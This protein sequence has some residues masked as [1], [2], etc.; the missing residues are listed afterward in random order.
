MKFFK[1]K[2]FFIA[3][4]Y[5]LSCQNLLAQHSPAKE[6]LIQQE[7]QRLQQMANPPSNLFFNG[8]NYDVNFYRLEIR[9]NPDSVKY[10]KG[11]VT[12][13]FKTTQSNVTNIVFDLASPVSYTAVKYHGSNLAASKINQ[14]GDDLTITLPNI[15][16]LGTLD[17]V[18]VFYE[19]VP[20]VV[21]YF[22]NGTGFVKSTHSGA[23]YIYTL[24]EPY[25]AYTWWPC[26]SM[27]A[28]DKADSMDIIISH[29]SGYKAAA[30]G[31]LVSVTGSGNYVTTFWKSRYPI[32]TYQVAI[33][34]AN[35]VQY[36]TTPDMVNIGGTMM[37][38]YNY[39]FPETNTSTARAVLDRTKLMLTTFSTYFGDYP[40]KNEKYG[41]YTFGFGG[42][43]EHNTFSGMNYGTY[44]SFSDWSVIAHELG[45]QWFG[46]NV[47]CGSWKDIWVNESFAQYSE[48][49][50]AELAPSV[51][52]GATGYSVR[53]NA[54]NLTMSSANQAKPIYADDT[55][56]INTI[57]TPAVY[58][59]ERGAMFISMLRKLLGDDNFFQ[60]IKNYQSDP[61]L[62]GGNAY[63]ND[64]KRHMEA[65]SGY[66]LTEMFNDW[67]YNTGVARYNGAK[68]NTSGYNTILYLPQTTQYSGI[69]HFNMPVVVKLSR[70]SPNQ[71][72]T[73]ILYDDNGEL[74][75]INNGVLTNSGTNMVQFKLSFVPTT[76][77][78]DPEN[79]TI[80]TG[81]FTKDAGMVLLATHAITLN[82]LKVGQDA[83]LNW[84]LEPNMDYSAMEL[85]RSTNNINF[86]TIHTIALPAP[87]TTQFNYTD[88]NVGEEVLYYRVKIIL[89]NGSE[90]FSKIVAL[91]TVLASGYY[92]ISPNPA[93][94]F[95]NITAAGATENV[96]LI[97]YSSEGK[98][99]KKLE[100][101]RI[102]DNKPIIISA[103]GI[104]AGNYFIDV[105][106]ESTDQRI[107]K[108][109]IL[110]P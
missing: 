27:V 32:S 56:N 82:G 107:T 15:P 62:K 87:N 1:T 64:V 106:R 101:Q 46:A 93:K 18:T 40:F 98:I 3:I 71:D 52:N 110:L 35:Y 39:L 24:S 61:L 36:P 66:D 85:Q 53:T 67:M 99:I 19:G 37:P 45:H 68:W 49:L 42:G 108:K 6:Q 97:I 63:T 20:P 47:T 4:L 38:F 77:T 21:P 5:V 70:T 89:R 48:I 59:Y 95:I 41:H 91:K 33:A 104:A 10:V 84:Q 78:F 90:E 14:V 8:D 86:E 2:L 23:N 26:K 11:K 72:T 22:G 94:D 75:Y 28:N 74:N 103:K 30:N 73:V 60:A 100:R 54:K 16:T 44:N 31:A 88:K 81:T 9:L 76:V 43:M 79:E 69:S 25:S 55:S 12:T 7:M 58:I 34:V 13:Y 65:V 109:L 92:T 57:F 96:N 29:P 51:T 83:K 50:C 105:I 102:G 80:A 17:S